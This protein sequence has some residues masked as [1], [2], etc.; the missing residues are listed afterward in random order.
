MRKALFLL[1]AIALC[2]SLCACGEKEEP[3][4]EKKL[5]TDNI[6]SFLNIDANVIDCDIQEEKGSVYGLFYKLFEG[7]A[8]I[9]IEVVNQSDAKFTDVTIECE[10]YTY[11]TCETTDSWYGWEFDYGNNNSGGK[12]HSDKNSKRITIKLPNDGNWSNTEDL[13]FVAYDSQMNFLFGP[14]ELTIC[15]IEIISVTGTVKY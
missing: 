8:Q 12:S 5:T 15:G 13:T 2:L 4:T 6:G 7:D 14:S 3:L 9:E 1:L 10:V 11:V